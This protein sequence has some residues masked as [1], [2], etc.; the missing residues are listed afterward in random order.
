LE[1]AEDPVLF[2]MDSLLVIPL[3]LID[4]DF[5]GFTE[6][7]SFAIVLSPKNHF[8]SR[9][10]AV[11][12]IIS[13]FAVLLTDKSTTFAVFFSHSKFSLNCHVINNR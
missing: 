2:L 10:I 8:F 13:M 9:P 7:L 5:C 4:E 1:S 3:P 6:L 11:G 12:S